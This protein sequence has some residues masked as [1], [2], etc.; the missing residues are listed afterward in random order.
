MLRPS[1]VCLF[2]NLWPRAPRALGATNSSSGCRVHAVIPLG[3]SLPSH[4]A[5]DLCHWQTHLAFAVAVDAGMVAVGPT[6]SQQAEVCTGC[7]VPCP[8]IMICNCYTD[9]H[10]ME[11]KGQ[12]SRWRA[13]E[14]TAA[15]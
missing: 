14:A 9:Q 12:N 3:G 10:I 13:Q 11:W 8:E 6:C 2:Q 7:I 5:T 4:H 15:T 1:A